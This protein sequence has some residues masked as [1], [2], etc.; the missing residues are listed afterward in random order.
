MVFRKIKPNSFLIIEKAT[1]SFQNLNKLM[2][3]DYPT[4][5]GRNVPRKVERWIRWI[6]PINER[7]KLN[8]DGSRIN[9]TSASSW[10][11]KDSNGIIKVA[12]SRHLGNASIIM[13][14]C[15]ALRDGI[16]V[17]TYNGFSNLE[18][19]G[20]SKVILDY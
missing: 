16:L 17:A 19:E 2:S 5:E 4:N 8:L 7:F 1:S 3:D 10:V 6:P 14:E 13:V 18:I 12:G 20:D 11:I 9:N 15:V